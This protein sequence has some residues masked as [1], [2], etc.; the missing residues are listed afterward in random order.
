MDPNP[1]PARLLCPWDSPGKNTGVG[2]H[3]FLQGSLPTQGLNSRL[4]HWH[5]GFLA[6][7]HLGSLISLFFVLNTTYSI[8]SLNAISFKRPWG[9]FITILLCCSKYISPVMK[10]KK[11]E[12][13]SRSV[14]SVSLWTPWTLAHQA[15]LSMKFCR[16]E[17]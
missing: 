16:Q 11:S 15:S 10:K 12:S 1:N 17:Y 9:V 2:C 5:A 4:M 13:V 3:A 14:V 8:C 6:V 7:S